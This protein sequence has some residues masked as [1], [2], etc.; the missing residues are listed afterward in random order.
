VDIIF[1]KIDDAHGPMARA[2]IGKIAASIA[3]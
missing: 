3:A 1:V 2:Y